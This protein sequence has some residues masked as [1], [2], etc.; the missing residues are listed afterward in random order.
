MPLP[1]DDPIILGLMAFWNQARGAR[2][3]PSKADIDPVRLGAR[4]LPHVL[5]VDV[6]DG[7]S[8]FRYR[9][10]GSANTDAA[11]IDLKGR[12]VDEL[13]PDPD[14]IRYM[15]GLYRRS[16]DMRRPVYSE[17]RHLA[18]NS[19]GIRDTRRLICPLAD[20]DGPIDRFISVQ[21]F[22][23]QGRGET[24]SMSRADRFVPSVIEVL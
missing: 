9:L 6:V 16:L 2:P 5:L 18:L 24:P 17:S 12:H 22:R 8:R 1:P 13:N 21:T 7:G 19:D 15:I 14:Y 23:Q 3:M 20:H 11:G 4:L 10:C